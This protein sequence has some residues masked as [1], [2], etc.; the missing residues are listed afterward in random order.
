MLTTG[1]TTSAATSPTDIDPPDLASVELLEDA[2]DAI[3][4]ADDVEYDRLVERVATGEVWLPSLVLGAM[5]DRDVYD[6]SFYLDVLDQDDDGLYFYASEAVEY[7]RDALN[8]IPLTGDTTPEQTYD[9]TEADELGVVMLDV[10]DRRGLEVPDVARTVLQSIDSAVGGIPD[11]SVYGQAI[12]VL[13][14]LE[15]GEPLPTSEPWGGAIDSTNPVSPIE[16]EAPVAQTPDAEPAPVAEPTSAELSPTEPNGDTAPPSATDGPASSSDNSTTLV[17]AALALAV[18]AILAT[19]YT[20][21]R[22]R[23]HDHL[24]DIAFTDSLTGLKNRRR[25]DAD[26]AEQQT[27]SQATATLMVDVDHF[28]Q[29][30]DVHGHSMGD[31]VLRLVGDTLSREFRKTDVPYRYGGEEFCVLLPDTNE[32]EALAAGERIRA[33]IEQIDLPIDDT[34]TASIGVSIGSASDITGTIERADEALYVA[35]ESGRNRVAL[36]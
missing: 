26:I 22:S 33:A 18:I 2:L 17:I 13:D 30:N 8:E 1:G 25:M 7:E 19:L 10:L 32:S 20:A 36:G 34:V 31:E 24:A 4:T 23:K 21:L 6:L 11:D 16:A 5:Y 14:A 35:K 3:E 9:I 28:K 15:A 12:D 29:F 27:K